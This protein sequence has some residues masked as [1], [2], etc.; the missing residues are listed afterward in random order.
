VVIPS[1]P[2]MLFYLTDHD[3]AGEEVERLIRTGGFEPVKVGGTDRSL[4][5][6]TGGSFEE[7]RRAVGCG[8][9]TRSVGAA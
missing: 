5:K 9:S 8:R 3:R 1:K 7:A 2:A 6:H 4:V